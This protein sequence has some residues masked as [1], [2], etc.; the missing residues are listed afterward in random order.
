M[1]MEN[2]ERRILVVYSISDPAGSGAAEALTK[3]SEWE[4]CSLD[5]AVSCL[6]EPGLGVYLAGF[7]DDSIHM[8]F[9]DEIA[10]SKTTAYIVL[11]R[12]SGGKPALTVHYTGNPGP[13]A[14]YG[15][16]PHEL[17]YTWPR[18]MASL[19]REYKRVAEKMGLLNEFSLSLEATHHG[20][21]S[22]ARPIVFI[23]IGSSEN[24]WR[25]RDTH[26]AMAETVYNVLRRGW[27]NEPCSKVAIG[28]GDTHYP[29][30][31]T[32]AVLEK[33][34][35]YTHIFSKH[36]LENLNEELLSQAVEKSRDP[37]DTILY[38]KI[39]SRIRS[40]IKMFAE[41]EELGVE[42]V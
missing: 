16:Q 20:P 35:C 13:E 33:G 7:R 14:P 24:E 26:I 19:L 22:L 27:L 17:S 10:P 4:K 5:R 1:S 37:V 12:H 18:L 6:Y 21:T 9:L 32:K 42:K 25:R 29:A 15:G 23:E 41:K 31:H 28:V 40:I 39:P 30:K 8:D 36:V 3:L 2:G 38:S 34:V 11:S